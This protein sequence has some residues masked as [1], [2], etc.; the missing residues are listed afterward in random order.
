V[1]IVFLGT[2]EF[3]RASLR[4]LVGASLRPALVVTPPP[5]RRARDAPPEPTAVHA[6]ADAA[7]LIVLTPEDVHEP[8]TLARIAASAPDLLVVADYG[9]ILQP[10][11]LSLPRFGAFNVHA[12]LLPRHRGATPIQA[13]IL[14]GDAE[15]GVTIQRM[16][17]RLDAGPILAQRA[18][19][20][21][22][23]DDAGS[24]LAR[25]APLGGDLV[26]EVCRE[27]AAGR[28]P[29]ERVQDE[30]ASS[31]SRRLDAEACTI[32]WSAPAADVWRRVRACSPKPG[33][34]T[35]LLREEAMPL[36]VRAT[37]PAEGEGAAGQVVD[38][39]GDA[40]AVACGR[41]VL[42]VSEV[43]PESRRFLTAREFLNGYRLRIGERF[44]RP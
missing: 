6:E 2:G 31:R 32:D 22:D 40:I 20:I 28:L 4:A 21:S 3:A 7:G 18:I 19:P 34:R 30:S 8:A 12:S 39:P 33:A 13:A 14:A 42:L 10:T 41:G 11:L 17:K 24:L 23:D 5:R 29:P 43:R 1:R 35:W 27:L 9:K 15:T 26:A 38:L 37:R 44:G 36:G 16:V 25:L